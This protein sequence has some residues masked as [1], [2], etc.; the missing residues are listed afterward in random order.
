MRNVSVLFIPSLFWT[1]GFRSRAA[2]HTRVNIVLTLS[3]QGGY[4]RHFGSRTAIKRWAR[5]D[6]LHGWCGAFNGLIV[7]CKRCDRTCLLFFFL[8]RVS[9]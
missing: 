5:G 4:A 2:C 8:S 6:F 1:L 9:G 3:Q 7:P